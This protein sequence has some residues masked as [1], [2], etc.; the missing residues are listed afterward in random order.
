MS[1]GDG[2]WKGLGERRG[3]EEDTAWEG[4]SQKYSLVFL[5]LREG[6]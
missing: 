4:I 3:T 1:T 2:P 5:A 6:A